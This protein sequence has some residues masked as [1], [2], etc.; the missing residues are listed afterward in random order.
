MPIIR[1]PQFD[2][3]SYR[4]QRSH[5]VHI[6]GPAG[7][8]RYRSEPWSARAFCGVLVG[9]SQEVWEGWDTSHEADTCPRCLEALTKRVR[10]G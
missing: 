5:M 10:R 8:K 1:F 7:H 2:I 9:F 6:V 4:V 3:W